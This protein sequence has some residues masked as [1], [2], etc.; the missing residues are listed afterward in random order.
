MP[1]VCSFV[2]EQPDYSTKEPAVAAEGYLCQW[3]PICIL[4]L[5]LKNNAKNN[6]NN[7]LKE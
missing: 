5:D 4:L 2:L 3:S 1:D 7:N 6:K